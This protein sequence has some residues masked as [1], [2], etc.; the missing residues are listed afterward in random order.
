M[1]TVEILNTK[2]NCSLDHKLSV[3][4][5]KTFDSCKA[6]FKFSYIEKLPKKE[7]DFH[8]FGTFLHDCLENFH[9]I[10]IENYISIEKWPSLMKSVFLESIEKFK[11]K[12]SNEQKKEAHGILQSYL[13]DCKNQ[14]NDG[15]LPTV[16]SVEQAF[17]ININNRVLLNGFI[18]RIQTDYDNVIHV[19]DYK[20]TK[21]KKYLKDF[22]QLQTYAFVLF[23]NDPSLE[24][25]RASFILLRHNNSFITEEY[26]RKDV[27]FISEK[28][29]KYADSIDSEK[30]WRPQPQF[31]C[32]YCD[33]IDNCDDGQNYLIKRGLMELPKMT[34]GFQKW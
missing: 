5:V 20:T 2:E 26:T 19:A 15:K 27:E 22:F 1:I 33:F 21:D 3:S 7:W 24:R 28:F 12:L 6:K 34:F 14:Y 32:K 9:K 16:T 23:L 17:N 25:V 29:L 8:I 11:D 4:K 31:L 18:D 13:I 10:I 30:V